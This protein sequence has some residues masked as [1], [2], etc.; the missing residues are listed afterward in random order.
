MNCKQF[1]N[2]YA[3]FCQTCGGKWEH[4]A[5]KNFVQKP[6]GSSY[7]QKQW[8]NGP[9]WAD[10]ESW[11]SQD[12]RPNPPKKERRPSK[13]QHRD[14]S[15]PR[16]EKKGKGKGK[17]KSGKGKVVPQEE[18]LWQ[19]ETTPVSAPKK[20]T[21]TAATSSSPEA[22]QLAK[23]LQVLKNSGE[24]L[25]PE[26]QEMEVDLVDVQ[27]SKKQLHSVVNQ[28]AGARKCMAE[29]AVAR[30]QLHMAWK[31]FL[32]DAVSRWEGY[33]KDFI[34]QDENL[35]A[36][37]AKAQQDWQSAK[38]NFRVAKRSLSGNSKE[39]KEKEEEEAQEISDVEEVDSK[40]EEE[41][42]IKEGITNMAEALQNLKSQAE[43]IA[44]ESAQAAKRQKLE[45][46]GSLPSAS[47]RGKRALQP[48]GA[49]DS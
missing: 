32:T 33:M 27:A 40:T 46:G 13:S 42:K 36:Q 28:I 16:H 23:L 3:G 12:Q 5:D 47:G 10:W 6:R 30:A 37:F 43:T 45:G 2:A 38:D 9:D 4:V 20:P 48:F 34:E 15:L 7:H 18:P 1:Q 44:A 35:A 14:T 24:A 41:T 25:A 19:P 21:Q 17:Q 8:E 49:A 39:E 29:T 11:R 22:A 31:A 26:V